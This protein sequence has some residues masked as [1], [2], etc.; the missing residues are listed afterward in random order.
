MDK[1]IQTEFELNLVHKLDTN[2][3]YPAIKRQN[4]YYTI[5]RIMDFSIALVL[6]LFLL[7]FLII[8]A[9]LIHLTSRGPILYKQERIGAVRVTNNNQPYWKIVTFICYKFRSMELG[10]DPSIHKAYVSALIN[11]DITQ[12]DKIQGKA[13][14]IRKMVHDPRITRV[15]KFLRKFSLDE[16][17]QFWNVLRGEM[18]LVGPRPAIS[19]E[20][21]VYKPW[22]MQRLQATPGITGLQQIKAR[23]TEDFDEQV[24]LDIEYIENQSI[25]LDLKICFLTPLVVLNAK[26][27]L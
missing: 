16:L 21:E 17:P 19:Y 26:G 24:K 15:G 23:C 10:A 12:M 18:S 8:I 14:D 13:S 7:P 11:N 5:K 6:L 2:D 9:I 1:L 20:V 4:S 27:A 25:V 3:L 22:H